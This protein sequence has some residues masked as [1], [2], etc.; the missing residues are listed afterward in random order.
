MSMPGIDHLYFMLTHYIC[1]IRLH[2]I[3]GCALKPLSFIIIFYLFCFT[4][5]LSHCCYLFLYCPYIYI[6]LT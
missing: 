3:K 2:F 1:S 6:T 4:F 5:Y